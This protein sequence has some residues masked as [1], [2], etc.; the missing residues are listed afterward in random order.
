[1]INS[2]IR[3]RFQFPVTDLTLQIDKKIKI[4]FSRKAADYTEDELA[5]LTHEA[6]YQINLVFEKYGDLIK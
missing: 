1:M 3:H 5:R 2:Y 6:E 4:L